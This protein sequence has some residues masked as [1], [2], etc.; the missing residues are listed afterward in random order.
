MRDEPKQP[1]QPSSRRDARQRRLSYAPPR[2]VE[3]GT[4]RDLTRGGQ[5]GIEDMDFTGTGPT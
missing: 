5:F 4:I 1:R 2:L 3:W